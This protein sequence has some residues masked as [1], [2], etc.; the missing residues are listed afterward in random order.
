MNTRIGAMRT[1]HTQVC[2][3]VNGLG[4]MVGLVVFYALGEV[5]VVRDNICCEG[6]KS[7]AKSRE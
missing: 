4:L 2:G 7:D 3:G 1:G 6:N 5:D